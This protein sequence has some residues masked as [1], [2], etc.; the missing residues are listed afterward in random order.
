MP[1]AVPKAPPETFGVPAMSAANTLPTRKSTPITQAIT[2]PS[3]F[4]RCPL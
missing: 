4:A 1:S 3:G 2:A